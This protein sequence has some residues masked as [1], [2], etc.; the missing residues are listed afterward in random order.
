[1]T[2]SEFAKFLKPII[3]GS[4]NTIEFTR[5]LFTMMIG[6]DN[7]TVIED[8]SDDSYKSYYNGKTSISGISKKILPY[9]DPENFVSYLDRFGD[10]VTQKLHNIFLPTIPDLDKQNTNEKIAYYFDE[11]IK[12]AASM[13]RKCTH[14]SANA[15]EPIKLPK[16][17][18]TTTFPYKI[19]DKDLLA[20]FNLDYDEIMLTLIGDNF[21]SV[22]IDMSLPAKIK[23]LY[24]EK[25]EN[26]SSNFVDLTLKSCVYGLLG[27][28]N[29]LSTSFISCNS[30]TT[31]IKNQREEI[32]NFYIKLHPETYDKAYPYDALLDDWNDS[33]F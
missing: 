13:Q 3:G 15:D 14:K 5:T 4:S 2:F 9:A 26:Y 31:L 20:E 1:M 27:T 8:L 30:D 7:F 22:L 28:L 18:V 19:E 23:K 21:A 29:E 17:Q 16:E 32:K 12:N 10:S 6:E 11:I 25:W 33:L 24:K